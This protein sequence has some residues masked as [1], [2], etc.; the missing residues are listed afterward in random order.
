M[1]KDQLGK[2]TVD[3]VRRLVRL[4]LLDYRQ[5]DT[6]HLELTANGR[7]V[8]VDLLHG[9]WEAENVTGKGALSMGRYL[10][11]DEPTVLEQWTKAAGGGR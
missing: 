4:K 8:V 3:T 2:V 10:G 5:L 1:H 7:S 11:L 6:D 9:T